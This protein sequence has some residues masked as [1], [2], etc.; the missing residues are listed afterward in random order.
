MKLE[1]P[2]QCSTQFSLP[3]PMLMRGACC[4]PGTATTTFGRAI[5]L[6]A[7]E[8]FSL[9][10]QLSGSLLARRNLLDY[11]VP[12]QFQI[13][14]CSVTTWHCC[15]LVQ[16]LQS[17]TLI[18]SVFRLFFLLFCGSLSLSGCGIIHFCPVDPFSFLSLFD[19]LGLVRTQTRVN[20]VLCV[21]S[22]A[23]SSQGS[24]QS[25]N[26]AVLGFRRNEIVEAHKKKGKRKPRIWGTHLAS[27]VFF[28]FF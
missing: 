27:S 11:M 24:V 18:L 12:K 8:H 26:L 5:E 16:G 19:L 6:P 22:T 14:T 7:T 2:S 17:E 1:P 13:S 10:F 21:R 23:H 28:F 9:S 4:D 25:A 15:A 3:R 20:T